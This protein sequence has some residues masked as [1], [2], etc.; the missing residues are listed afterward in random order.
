LF[1]VIYR[2]SWSTKRNCERNTETFRGSFF[3]LIIARLISALVTL[4]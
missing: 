1:I 4:H 2:R 3:T